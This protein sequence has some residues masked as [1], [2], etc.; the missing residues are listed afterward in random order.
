M[1]LEHAGPMLSRV[2]ENLYWISRYVERAEHVARL[3]DN[4]YHR[5]LDA[6]LAG[7]GAGSLTA[8]ARLVGCASAPGGPG[9]P[10]STASPSTATAPIRSG[11]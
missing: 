4:A 6:G 8:V 9:G 11:R 1:I 2:A 5:E 7:G 10:C 3:L